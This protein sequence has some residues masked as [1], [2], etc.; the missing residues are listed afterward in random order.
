MAEQR[1]LAWSC[2]ACPTGSWVGSGTG[3]GGT[4]VPRAE[5]QVSKEPLNHELP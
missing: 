1:G 5:H 4:T 2:R 3:G